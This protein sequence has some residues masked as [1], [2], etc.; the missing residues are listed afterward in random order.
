MANEI[1]PVPPD[2]APKPNDPAIQAERPSPTTGITS[3]TPPATAPS[4]EPASMLTALTAQLAFYSVVFVGLALTVSVLFGLRYLGLPF[5]AYAGVAAVVF[6][7]AELLAYRVHYLMRGPATTRTVRSGPIP[8]ND[9]FREVVETIVFVVVLV[10]MLKS[11]AAEAFVIPTGSMAETLWGYQ[12]VVTCPSCKY[13]FPINASQQVDPTNPPATFLCGG[14]C[15]NCRQNILFEE[16]PQDLLDSIRNH[17]P[18]F[19]RTAK[20]IADPGWSSG[21]R[22]LVAKFI[23][24]LLGRMPDRLDVVVFK[25]PGESETGPLFPASGP[26]KNHVAMNYIKRLI[27]LPGETILICGGKLYYLPAS[28]G[29]KYA[30]DL[31]GEDGKP[32]KGDA[33]KQRLLELWQKKW[34][35]ENDNEARVKFE[36]GAFVIIR[37][38]PETILAMRRIVFDNDHQPTNDAGRPLEPRWKTLG[39]W[40]SEE[41]D[42]T[43][44]GSASNSG[45]EWLVYQHILRDKD[46][47]ELITDFMGYNSNEPPSGGSNASSNWVGDLM[48]EGDFTV[49]QAAGE[50]RLD[51]SKGIDRFQARFDLAS[52]VCTL[53]RIHDGKEEKLDS[54]E[55]PLKAGK[56]T[57]SIRFANVDQKLTLWV[58]NT[59]PFGRDGTTYTVD[60]PWMNG[61]KK[62]DLEKPV[63]IGIK[64]GE[65]TVRHLKLWRDTYYTQG[66]SSRSAEGFNTDTPTPDSFDLFPMH[67]L[68]VQPNHFLC[69]GDNSPAS[70]DGRMWGLVPERLLLGRAVVVYYPFYFPVWPFNSQVNRVGMI[71]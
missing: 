38:S 48:I 3:A 64:G 60:K 52:G 71:K 1:P 55:T 6:I 34:I 49:E 33:L 31:N 8:H 13:Q 42:R 67:S 12:K 16:S 26:F 65:V 47:P 62:S 21:D 59:F 9:G 43:F 41:G 25:F 27:G 2:P 66:S 11:F 69:M 58:N 39:Q 51:L 14:T 24:D 63:Q 7:A 61:P 20:K 10:L 50:L 46:R 68:Y 19:V 17:N 29:L 5:L 30:E 36:N 35:H 56:G 18:D 45:F 32:L 22:V 28:A 23:Y 53:T 4:D 37:K 44:R 70:S 57:Y 15:P 54:R 40:K